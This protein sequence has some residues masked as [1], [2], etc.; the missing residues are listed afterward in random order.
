MNML[1]LDRNSIKLVALLAATIICFTLITTVSAFN[2]KGRITKIL[3]GKNISSEIAQANSIQNELM[4]TAYRLN[5]VKAE[6]TKGAEE[7]SDNSRINLILESINK[8]NLRLTKLE[9]GNTGQEDGLSYLA[10]KFEL[11]GRYE[12]ILRLLENIENDSYVS[13]IVS[14]AQVSPS[15]AGNEQQVRMTVNLYRQK[16]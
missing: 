12:D 9:C 5:K 16:S 8:L 7:L 6:L 1:R 4:I 14:L 13:R 10:V 15:P 3:K 2:V 11:G